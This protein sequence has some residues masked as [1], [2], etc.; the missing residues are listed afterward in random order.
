M[1]KKAAPKKVKKED[2][3]L[4]ARLEVWLK[5]RQLTVLVA[6][7]L[8]VMFA[9]LIVSQNETLLL[10]ELTQDVPVASEIEAFPA[11]F[12]THLSLSQSNGVYN[13]GNVPRVDLEEILKKIESPALE[14][15]KYGELTRIED[16][17]SA[18]E[19][20]WT[21]KADALD[22]AG[23][24]FNLYVSLYQPIDRSRIESVNDNT[25]IIPLDNK[26]QFIALMR[27]V[28]QGILRTIP[29]FVAFEETSPLYETR[30]I[31][32]P[33]FLNMSADHFVQVSLQLGGAED[34][35]YGTVTISL[36]D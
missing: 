26:W 5:D 17:F 13:A 16:V 21:L 7:A 35:Q 4:R 1:S 25:L 8:I 33:I 9:G 19:D 2:R 22:A 10:G 27:D 12:F 32:R 23:S 18:G 28:E 29:T 30:L 11:D 15:L 34:E 24:F 6:V 14:L 20:I 31:G 36:I 3:S